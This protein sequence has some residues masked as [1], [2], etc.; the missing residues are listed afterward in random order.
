MENNISS[1]RV[2]FNETSKT[3]N[4]VIPNANDKD[5]AN[6]TKFL[7]ATVERI[8]GI[9]D[10]GI[11]TD[12]ILA[13]KSENVAKAAPVI[14]E[15]KDDAPSTKFSIPTDAEIAKNPIPE[16]DAD[17]LNLGL[18]GAK[19]ADTKVEPPI[20]NNVV[21]NAS[22]QTATVKRDVYEFNFGQHE[23]KKILDFVNASNAQT[24]YNYLA[25]ILE[26]N[27]K[28]VA[29]KRD[30]IIQDINIATKALF[31]SG[32]TPNEKCTFEMARTFLRCLSAEKVE[33]LLA[34]EGYGSIDEAIKANNN[35]WFSQIV[36]IYTATL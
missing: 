18:L 4:I 35:E 24:A 32:Y 3:L 25:F 30:L 9:T 17:G 12:E 20:S 19:P 13:T 27:F 5:I 1:V 36:S 23:G 31:D 11:E 7:S 26:K 21:D 29:E 16:D 14:P 33:Q 22:E 2:F 6:A 10:N 8:T 28:K 34:L 15:K